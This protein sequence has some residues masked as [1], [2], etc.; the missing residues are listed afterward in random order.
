ADLALLKGK[1]E[2]PMADESHVPLRSINWREAFP[3][4]QIFRAFRVAI[5]PS[6]LMLALAALLCLY[7]GGRVLDM[8][9]PVKYKALPHFRESPA[10]VEVFAGYKDTD[11]AKQR[12]AGRRQL[13]DWYAGELISRKVVTDQAAAQQAA[14]DGDKVGELKDKLKSERDEE[15]KRANEAHNNAI[16]EANKQTDSEKKKRMRDEA[17]REFEQRVRAA[18]ANAVRQ[19]EEYEAV[20]G[21]G[22]FM[23]FFN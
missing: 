18:H 1:G 17:D 15:V 22:P 4:S 2:P 5:H 10:E 8:L 14:R 23:Q 9:W 7:A 13:E 12:E 3:F 6:K 16:N 20:K 19:G 11:F 21:Q